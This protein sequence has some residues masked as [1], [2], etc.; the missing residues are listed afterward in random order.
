MRQSYIIP[1]HAP[2]PSTMHP[3]PQPNKEKGIFHLI[4]QALIN[5]SVL[6]K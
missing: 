2:T 1:N 3:H 5:N 4:S 6:A